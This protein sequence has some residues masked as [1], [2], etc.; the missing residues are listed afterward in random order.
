MK[1][2]EI[3]QEIEKFAPLKHQES[4]DNSGIQIGDSQ[5]E[6]TGVLICVDV[7]EEVLQEA[8]EKGCNL[9][10]SHHPLIFRGIKK[11][12]PSDSLG[13]I[14]FKAIENKIAIYSS[15]TNMDKAPQGVSYQ[16]AIQLGIQVERPLVPETEDPQF[17]LGIVGTLAEEM[18][19]VDFLAEVKRKLKL[20]HIRHTDIPQDKSVKKIALCGGSAFEFYK[21]AITAEAD[22]YL[23]ADIKYHQYF[24]P[25]NKIVIAD[26]GHYE[27]EQF[28]KDIFYN[29]VSGLNSKNNAKFA[30]LFSEHP[31]NPVNYL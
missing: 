7:T 31:S 29:I 16:T 25:E 9:I 21:D 26:I 27:S 13:R 20:G 19:M 12:I 3:I 2:I 11:V 14:I 30:L 4:Y 17:G 18:K 22:L 28:V 23:T 10:L 1:I 5:Q 15:H 8:I 6:V 24:E